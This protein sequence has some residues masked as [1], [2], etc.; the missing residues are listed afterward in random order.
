MVTDT[1]GNFIPARINQLLATPGVKGAIMRWP[2]GSVSGDYRLGQFGHTSG[3]VKSSKW[4]KLKVDP[5]YKFIEL[6][7]IMDWSVLVVINGEDLYKHYRSG[8]I[9]EFDKSSDQAI[10]M[11]AIFEHHGI[12]VEG[13]EIGNELQIYLGVGGEYNR[14][15]AKYNEAVDDMFGITE[16]MHGRIKDHNPKLLTGAC[17]VTPKSS[18]AN[19][20]DR[21]WADVFKD[22]TCD[23]LIVHHYEEDTNP[24][25][26]QPTLN[27]MADAIHYLGFKSWFTEGMWNFGPGTNHPKF[28][29]SLKA[30]QT[31]QSYKANWF[32]MVTAADFDIACFHRLAVDDAH[33]YNFDLTT[34]VTK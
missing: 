32:N 18:S 30:P 19:G 21:R 9:N 14:N 26:W 6:C 33:P 12:K 7:R 10:K 1:K 31:W 28:A 13:V 17:Y 23:A 2:G 27:G 20:R 11:I 4:G 15:T 29:A 16:I 8:N 3:E 25:T 34:T 24:A 5:I 22:S